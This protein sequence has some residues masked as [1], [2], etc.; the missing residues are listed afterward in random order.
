MGNW[1]TRISREPTAEH[2]REAVQITEN[3]EYWVPSGRRIPI[4]VLVRRSVKGTTSH[5]T[6]GSARNLDRALQC[7]FRSSPGNFCYVS[8]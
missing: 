1:P 6:S 2:G 7:R 5:P 4:A 8:S 3:G